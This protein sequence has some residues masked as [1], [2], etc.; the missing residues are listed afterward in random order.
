MRLVIKKTMG[1]THKN[2]SKLFIGF[3]I[4][5]VISGIA[6]IIQGQPVIGIPGSII[7]AWL[8]LQNV[9]QLRKG[10]GE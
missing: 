10:K 8:I 5:T 9:Q 1:T 4:I 7:G 6:L 2:Q 3:G